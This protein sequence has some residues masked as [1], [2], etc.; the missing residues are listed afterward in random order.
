MLR[1]HLDQ[2]LGQIG[3]LGLLRGVF[4][5]GFALGQRGGHQEVFGAGDGHH[6][7]RNARALEAR[8]PCGN[9]ATM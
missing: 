2:H 8:A 4:Q 9:L 5:N 6:V 7:G 1:A 3:N